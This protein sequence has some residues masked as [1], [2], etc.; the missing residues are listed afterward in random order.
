MLNTDEFFLRGTD[1]VPTG[2][3]AQFIF[4][5]TTDRLYFDRDGTGSE[6][7]IL[8]NDFDFTSPLD[9]LTIFDFDVV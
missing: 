2:T 1:L 4:L 7:A 3:K 6:A 9:G 5:D 8:V